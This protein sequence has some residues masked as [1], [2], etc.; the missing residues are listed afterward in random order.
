MRESSGSGGS[1]GSVASG[2][3]ARKYT[4]NLCILLC[5]CIAVGDFIFLRTR[6]YHVEGM[7]KYITTI[8]HQATRY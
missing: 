5:T 4:D 7:T 1:T 3:P 6:V 2:Y 8:A